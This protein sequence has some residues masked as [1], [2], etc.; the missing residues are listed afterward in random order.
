MASHLPWNIC[1]RLPW[2]IRKRLQNSTHVLKR[3]VKRALDLNPTQMD[4][5]MD[6]NQVITPPTKTC[7]LKLDLKKCRIHFRRFGKRRRMEVIARR[8]IFRSRRLS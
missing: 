8:R 6:L 4:T 7:I 3:G 2:N 5:Q 1:K